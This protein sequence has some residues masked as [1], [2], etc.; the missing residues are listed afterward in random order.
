MT[1]SML[2]EAVEPHIVWQ[3]LLTAVLNEL[4]GD[5]SRNEV[6]KAPAWILPNTH[7]PINIGCPFNSL[8]PED[9]TC[10]GRRDSG[11]SLTNCIHRPL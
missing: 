3:Q 6:R 4:T 1:A 7:R 5:G 10:P 9:H 11:C 2:Y 8:H